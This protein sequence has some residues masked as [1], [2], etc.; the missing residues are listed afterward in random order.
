M[1]KC[2]DRW[3]TIWHISNSDWQLVFLQ[4]W[5]ES[6]FEIN[7]WKLKSITRSMHKVFPSS[8]KTGMMQQSEWS[9]IEILQKPQDMLSIKTGTSVP[10]WLHAVRMVHTNYGINKVNLL[11]SVDILVNTKNWTVA[12][13][14]E[15]KILMQWIFTKA[16]QNR[17]CSRAPHN[18]NQIVLKEIKLLY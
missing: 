6:G 16:R 7:L 2:F 15:R 18:L 4:T 3:P 1:Q 5:Q 10:I 9:Q 17:K 12:W 14:A 13:K 11:F 8:L